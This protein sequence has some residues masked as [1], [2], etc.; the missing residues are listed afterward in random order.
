MCVFV[1]QF[2]AKVIL[3]KLIQNFEMKLLPNTKLEITQ[4]TTLRPKYGVP[5]TLNLKKDR[6][7]KA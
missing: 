1:L 3:A 4:V 5:V 7:G 6:S 2:E